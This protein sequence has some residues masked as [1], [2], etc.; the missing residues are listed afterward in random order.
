MCLG[1]DEDVKAVVDLYI[2]ETIPTANIIK[3]MDS[4]GGMV[5]IV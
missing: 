5:V 3:K 2:V 1:G 4:K